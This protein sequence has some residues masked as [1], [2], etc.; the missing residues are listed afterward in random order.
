MG[1]LNTAG[2]I[3]SSGGLGAVVGAVGSFLNKMEERK[4]L[5]LKLEDKKHQREF[6]LKESE[7]E[8]QHTIHLQANFQDPQQTYE[9]YI[10]NN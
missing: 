9:L 1:L 2:D 5:K 7:L 6:E 3:L 10:L 8:F 4:V